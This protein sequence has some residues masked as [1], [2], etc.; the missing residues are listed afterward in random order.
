VKSG[1]DFCKSMGGGGELG[2][3]HRTIPWTYESN[4]GGEK[5]SSTCL[6]MCLISMYK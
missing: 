2:A 6:L 1:F 4:K 3:S 5:T